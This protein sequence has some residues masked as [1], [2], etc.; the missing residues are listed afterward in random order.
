MLKSDVIVIGGG[1]AGL[2]AAA[3]SAKR[4][5]K[6]TLLTY[7]SGS[8]PLNSGLIDI[9]AK[10]VSGAIAATPLQGISELTEKHPYQVIGADVLKE[11]VAFFM[12]LCEEENYPYQ[13]SLDKHQWVVT[14]LGTMKPS[15]LVP[16]TMIGNYCFK[17]QDIVL[18]GFNGLKDHYSNV[19]EENLKNV[20]ENGK[21]YEQVIIYPDI[22]EGRDLTALDIARWVSTT[23]GYA[24]CLQQLRTVVKPGSVVILP[25]VLGVKPDYAVWEQLRKDLQCD[26][27][28]STGLPPS[29]NGLRL[30][31]LLLHYLKKHNVTIIENCQ[32]IG[33]HIQDKVCISVK[34]KAVARERIYQAEQFIL[35][36]GGF[37][38]GGLRMDHFPEIKEPIFNIPVHFAGDPEDWANEELFSQ[39]KQPFALVG[40]NTDA[41]MHPLDGQGNCFLTNVHVVG[42]NLSGYDFCFE[43]S[44]NGVALVSAYQAAM[45]V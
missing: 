32:V 19:M 23:E 30:R 9:M 39:Q 16:K 40:I 25:Q 4:G 29:A 38:G 27:M 31:S 2:M 14:A 22:E 43:Q 1:F 6:V 18:V 20:L 13:G 10:P 11:A 7:G 12:G 42:R 26:V 36:T 3:V 5:K 17:Q 15:C 41:Q 44:G 28:E 45:S 33:S 35:A 37:Y 8:F 24:A 34:A 21:N